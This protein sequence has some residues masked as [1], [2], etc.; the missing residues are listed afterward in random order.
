MY[1]ARR[2]GIIYVFIYFVFQRSSIEHRCYS[3][4]ELLRKIKHTNCILFYNTTDVMLLFSGSVKPR[5]RSIF[6]ELFLTIVLNVSA[7]P[8]STPTPTSGPACRDYWRSWSL[9]TINWMLVT[10]CPTLN[11]TQLHFSF[12][13]TTHA[14][15]GKWCRLPTVVRHLLVNCLVLMLQVY[16]IIGSVKNININCS[17]I[18]TVT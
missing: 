14:R 17:F 18:P 15:P 2:T 1:F 5:F 11:R 7:T 9:K 6:T 3:N 13:R 12:S 4:Y 10:F 16:K 8:W